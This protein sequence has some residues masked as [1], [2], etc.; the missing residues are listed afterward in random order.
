MW[1]P[2]LKRF[3]GIEPGGDRL[4]LPPGYEEVHQASLRSVRG[5]AQD[6]RSD[7]IYRPVP[8]ENQQ[9]LRALVE[10]GELSRTRLADLLR[11]LWRVCSK[12]RCSPTV[13]IQTASV[14]WPDCP[15]DRGQDQPVGDWLIRPQLL[16]LGM[17]RALL[18]GGHR[19]LP[20]AMCP[21]GLRYGS[22]PVDPEN[23]EGPD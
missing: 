19:N 6:K 9:A 8:I 10:R 7:P 18:F 12:R 11:V 1:G 3:R 20:V 13:A 2:G 5:V 21:A 14:P 16:A 15:L 22:I 17:H 23:A 4:D